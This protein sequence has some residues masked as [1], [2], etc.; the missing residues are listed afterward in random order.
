MCFWGVAAYKALLS[1]TQLRECISK[2]SPLF[3]VP[4]LFLQRMIVITDVWSVL[5][6]RI[7]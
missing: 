3:N 5:V 1:L 6:E 4:D 2:R 7:I